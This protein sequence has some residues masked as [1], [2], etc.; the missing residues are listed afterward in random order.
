M[1]QIVALQGTDD[2]VLTPGMREFRYGDKLLQ[3]LRSEFAS[4]LKKRVSLKIKA[5][6]THRSHLSNLLSQPFLTFFARLTGE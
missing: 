4:R 3:T 5:G 2:G 6:R 1:L